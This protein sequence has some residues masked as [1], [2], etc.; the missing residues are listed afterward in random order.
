MTKREN[1]TTDI[2]AQAR[3]QIETIEGPANLGS[4]DQFNGVHINGTG[5]TIVNG[6]N[7]NGINQTFNG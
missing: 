3:T 5:I 1:D 6:D 7:P 2:K 4:G